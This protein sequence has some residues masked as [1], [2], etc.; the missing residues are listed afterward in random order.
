MAACAA[1]VSASSCRR[2]KTPPEPCSCFSTAAWTSTVSTRRATPRC[3]R[4]STAATRWSE[5]SRHGRRGSSRTRRVSHR[6]RPRRAAAVAAAAAAAEDHL[7][8]RANPPWRSSGST[9]RTRSLLPS[10]TEKRPPFAAL[11]NCPRRL[12]LLLEL[13]LLFRERRGAK[14]AE[15]VEM[16][17]RF[18]GAAEASQRHTQGI[19][20]LRVPG[21]RRD[22]AA[23]R[24]FGGV[25]PL[26]AEVNLADG[27]E[28]F[29]VLG[30]KKRCHQQLD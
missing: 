1:T 14:P 13:T 4:R 21:V 17:F 11:R 9:T 28:G 2:P 8:S 6:L 26:R 10:R 25:E 30:A 27:G 16:L 5:C 22:G 19:A 7:A 12:R 24:A 20:R 15:L 29:R 23:Q 18:G 3:T